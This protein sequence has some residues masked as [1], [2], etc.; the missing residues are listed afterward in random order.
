MPANQLLNVFKPAAAGGGGNNIAFDA[1]STGI[2]N[3]GTSLTFAHTCTGSNRVLVVGVSI[4]N[5]AA[6]LVTGVTYSGVAMTQV[7]NDGVNTERHYL[8]VLINPASGSNNVVIS[9]S[10][11]QIMVGTA[12]SYTGAR[13][14]TQPEAQTAN[15]VASATTITT[16]VTTI[17]DNSWVVGHARA[18]SGGN[19]AAGASTT[20]RTAAI[21]YLICDSGGPVS[22]PGVRG[23]TLTTTP[24]QS[25]GLQA[26][27]IAST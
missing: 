11:S 21:S 4:I 27:A 16:N 1:A 20:L 26:C 7:C 14:T 19:L 13:Q 23:L 25:I 8:Y 12:S 18:S 10:S 2:V 9:A 22:P 15:S 17:A 6:D 3:P 5:N 24:A